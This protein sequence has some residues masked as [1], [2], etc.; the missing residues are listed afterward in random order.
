M[1][2]LHDATKGYECVHRLR[3]GGHTGPVCAIDFSPDAKYLRTVSRE[4]AAAGAVA[5]GSGGV[6]G[7][8][9][10]AAKPESGSGGSA[11]GV[12]TPTGHALEVKYWNAQTGKVVN[13]GYNSLREVAWTTRSFV[14][15]PALSG[16]WPSGRA[17][18]VGHFHPHMVGVHAGAGLAFS[19]AAD[20]SVVRVFRFPSRG[21]QERASTVCDRGH[22][23][24]LA[25][26]GWLA[27]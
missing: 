16:V 19:A 18:G 9:G 23:S 21:F 27:R 2:Y 12:T 26:A 10:G 24:R 7:G 8:G 25:G 1:V 11:N 14:G 13:D 20:S 17:G 4:A 22:A 5:A 15:D 6:G 3:V